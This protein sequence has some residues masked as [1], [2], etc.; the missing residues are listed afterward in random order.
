MLRSFAKWWA[1]TSYVF[2]LEAEAERGDIN[3]AIARRNAGEHRKLAEQINAEADGIEKRIA[4]LSDMEEGG[5]WQCEDGHEFIDKCICNGYQ[6][7]AVVHGEGC[8]LAVTPSTCPFPKCSA[9][10]KLVKRSDMTGKEKYESDQER[11]D[12]EKMMQEKRELAK[13]KEGDA[14]EAER[15]AQYLA[16][17]A[18]NSRA[19]ANKIRHL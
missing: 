3:A 6:G 16:G 19:F 7:M 17:L 14:A 15:N 5:Y 13:A 8:R 4:E 10:V 18:E 2:K 11:K 12:A 1:R 9:P